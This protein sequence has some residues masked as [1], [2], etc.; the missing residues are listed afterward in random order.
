MPRVT[1]VSAPG[2]SRQRATR[3][4]GGGL[5]PFM[6]ARRNAPPSSLNAPKGQH[7][8]VQV[9]QR[10]S[11][12]SFSGFGNRLGA[13]LPGSSASHPAPTPTV[14]SCRS[15]LRAGQ[16]AFP[17]SFP[18]LHFIAHSLRPSHSLVLNR[19]TINSAHSLWHSRLAQCTLLLTLAPL[20]FALHLPPRR[21]SSA[22]LRPPSPDAPSAL[23]SS[24]LPCSL[25]L[26]SLARLRRFMGSV[27]LRATQRTAPAQSSR[28]HGEYSV[29]R[30]L[31]YLHLSYL[32]KF[33]DYATP[34]RRQRAL[35][36]RPE[37]ADDEC[38]D[39]AG[40]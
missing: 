24:L 9:T 34:R 2:R 15:G 40:G 32:G 8:D 7:A 3:I 29:C 14:S 12:K 10:T 6:L 16:G 1:K 22:R 31:F 37:K 30:C 13:P 5:R 17:L 20:Q 11:T 23:L 33:F 35:C 38:T 4:L 21:L 39:T 25:P 27:D 19:L 36:G 26:R 28:R 18:F